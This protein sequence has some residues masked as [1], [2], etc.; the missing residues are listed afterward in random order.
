ML[1]SQINVARTELLTELKAALGKA[2]CL[3]VREN[4][5]E[6]KAG[7]HGC[8]LVS[9]LLQCSAVLL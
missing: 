6:S 8:S 5:P 3:V 2:I 7:L 4:V 1:Q 9:L